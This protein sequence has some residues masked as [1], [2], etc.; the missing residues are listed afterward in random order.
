M[1]A[2]QEIALRRGADQ[3]PAFFAIACAAELQA[4]A[5][6]VPAMLGPFEQL[7]FD[8]LRFAPKR[9]S[10]L[11]GRLAAKRA[12]GAMLGETDLRA[13]A[14]RAGVFGQPL[15]QHPRAL[16]VDVTL[17]HSNGVAVALVFP[18][19]WPMGIDLESVADGAVAA[20]M[21]ELGTS[22]D[23]EAWL[24]DVALEKSA[25]CGVLW[26]AREALGKS[27][28][29]GLNSPLALFS[30][31]GIVGASGTRGVGGASGTGG[32]GGTSG[33]SGSSQPPTAVNVWA[34]S[35][36]NFPQAKWIA[37]TEGGRVMTL[38]IPREVEI[39]ALPLL[40]SL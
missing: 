1:S 26:G 24:V 25:A 9:Q 30:T 35:Y 32:T 17:S 10:F 14:I 2:V 21:A 19:D 12:L 8:T 33:A 29:T 20:V 39:A 3:R 22:P 23:E 5:A 16:G 28:K 11:L 7:L 15:I 37:N 4:H 27:L 13:I 36:T 18:A 31:C 34:G 6:D 40:S 38:A